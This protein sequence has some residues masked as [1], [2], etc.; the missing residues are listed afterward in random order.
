MS[1]APA[2][3]YI[4]VEAYLEMEESSETK[5]EYYKGEIFAMAGGTVPHNQ[6]IANASIEIGSH[7]RGKKCQ[8]FPSDQKI[9]IEANS[10]F[11]YPDLS[12]VCG[13]P[14]GWNS[15]N[16]TITNPVVIIEVLSKATQGYDRGQKF[17]LYRDIPTLQQYILISSLEVLIEKYTRQSN[18]DWLLQEI[19]DKESTFGLE[20][21]DF[22]VPVSEFYRNVVFE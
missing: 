7:L 16:D 5:N 15:R 21:I 20:T 4:D 14:E 6:I 18:G 22:S 12:I 11:T 3:K 9:H 1:A 8:I 19:T 10:L 17:K 2:L 13:E